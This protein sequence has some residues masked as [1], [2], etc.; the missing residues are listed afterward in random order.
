MK[1]L[2]TLI[3]ALIVSAGMAQKPA[4]TGIVADSELLSTDSLSKLSFGALP[5]HFDTYSL[6][7]INQHYQFKCE[8]KN[9]Y[10]LIIQNSFKVG[11]P[12]TIGNTVIYVK[13]SQL[14]WLNDSTAIVN[15]ISLKTR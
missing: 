10:S 6:L 7:T 2:L 3:L 4:S 12:D 13:K 8:A 14:R 11:L 1:Y 9:C 5:V 15:A